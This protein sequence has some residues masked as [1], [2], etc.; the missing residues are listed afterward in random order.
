MNNAHE[1]IAGV[2]A[3]Y[4]E[5]AEAP[6]IDL[7]AVAAGYELG[8][9]ATARVNSAFIQHALAILAWGRQVT[10]TELARLAGNAKTPR[11]IPI[12]QQFY[13]VDR[14]GRE[15]LVAHAALTA[16]ERSYIEAARAEIAKLGLWANDDIRNLIRRAEEP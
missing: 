6:V 13:A 3:A 8:R 15:I 12:E 16:N 9:P 4:R 10:D 14:Y 11:Y 1:L 7:L 2:R 5:L